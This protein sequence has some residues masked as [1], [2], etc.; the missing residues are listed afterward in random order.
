[1]YELVVQGFWAFGGF[2]V[3]DE[4]VE[5]GV[6]GA[7]F[8]D[9]KMLIRIKTIKRIKLRRQIHAINESQI[10]KLNLSRETNEEIKAL[11]VKL[12]R[13]RLK[14]PILRLDKQTKISQ[15]TRITSRKWN[16]IKQ[17]HQYSQRQK[18]TIINIRLQEVN[19]TRKQGFS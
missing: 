13:Y 8:E 3:V 15:T 1:M 4:E 9:L 6:D 2:E 10:K 16:F 17:L 5:L 12:R 19:L 7:V 18:K 11:L 14:A